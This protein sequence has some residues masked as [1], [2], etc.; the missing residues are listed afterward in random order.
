[1]G[2]INSQIVAEFILEHYNKMSNNKMADEIMKRYSVLLEEKD[3]AKFLNEIGIKKNKV[4]SGEKR[5]V[6][7]TKKSTNAKVT[8]ASNI[9]WGFTAP[10]SYGVGKYK[11]YN[12]T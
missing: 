9:K 8:T 4:F 12:E 5:T 7:E 3:I 1:M 11:N 10:S 2:T 6:K